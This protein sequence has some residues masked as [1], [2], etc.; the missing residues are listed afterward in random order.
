VSH[1]LNPLRVM[2]SGVVKEFSKVVSHYQLAYCKTVM[3]RNRR[4]T[5]PVM[6]L[7]SNSS[8]T[9]VKPLLL[10]N[11]F[12][13]DPYMLPRTKHWVEPH[14]RPHEST[15]DY[16]SADSSEEEGEEEGEAEG[17]EDGEE[18][19]EAE[20][21][22]EA[23]EEQEGEEEATALED[24]LNKVRSRSVSMSSTASTGSASRGRTRKLSVSDVMLHEIANL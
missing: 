4:I 7:S 8:S 6:G 22:E 15:L 20:E 5:L 10:D 18:D 24:I 1:Q 12:P 19:G 14:Y 23:E 9:V 21:E 16:E 13:F 2:Q 3:E 17:E 11:Y